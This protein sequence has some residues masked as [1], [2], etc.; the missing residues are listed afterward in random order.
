MIVS[1]LER[2]GYEVFLPE[3]ARPGGPAM[4]VLTAWSR[5]ALRAD[6]TAAVPLGEFSHKSACVC[7]L[8]HK[9]TGMRLAVS[10]VHLSVPIIRGEL[11]ERH[12]LRE[13]AA[14][15]RALDD[16]AALRECAGGTA[17]PATVLAGDFN[18]LPSSGVYRALIERGLASCYRRVLGKEPAY[19]T[20]NSPVRA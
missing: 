1:A 6:A 16:A 19:T 15:L 3:A 13:L 2:A 11:D 10:N 5:E 14:C 18:A 7:T 17:P 9:L 4:T 20:V 8:R 12:Q